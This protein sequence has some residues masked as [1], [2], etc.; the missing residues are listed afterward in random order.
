MDTIIATC[1]LICNDCIAYV[2]TQKD[3]DKLRQQVVEAWTTESERRELRDINCD[4]CQV[5]KRIYTFCSTCDVRKCGQEKRVANCGHCFEY[6][7]EKLER[8]WEGFRT[9]SGEEA[10]RTLD[11]I[12]SLRK[13]E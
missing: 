3:D 7:C 1:G 10:K 13:F 4:G 9:V 5:G 6:P 11:T 12:R 2:A 8:L